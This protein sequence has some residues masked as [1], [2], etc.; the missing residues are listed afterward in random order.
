MKMWLSVAGS[1]CLLLPGASCRL[2]QDRSA[3]A[4]ASV[5]NADDVAAL[6]R[7]R[8]DW[9]N[10][11]L[12][13]DADALAALYADDPVL[14]PQSQPEVVGKEAIRSLY[15]SVFEEYTVQGDGELLE[16]EVAG[17]WAFYRSTYRLKATP[18][19]GGEPIEDTGKSLFIVRRQPD[20]SWKIARLIA[21]SDLPPAD[22]S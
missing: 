11:W 1:I 8:E 4:A 2:A 5:Q 19:A 9:R 17:D 21:N 16:V 20:G 6:M 14:M 18:K 15:Q 10:G 22:G 7:L 3:P 13:G 12:A